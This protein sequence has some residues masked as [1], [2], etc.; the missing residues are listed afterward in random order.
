MTTKELANYGLPAKKFKKHGTSYNDYS[1]GVEQDKFWDWLEKHREKV[2]LDPN[3][4]ERNEILPEP[5][6][7]QEVM[8]NGVAYARRKWSKK[9]EK[10]VWDM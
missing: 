5:V 1:F 8:V 2:S 9:L 10:T 4:F 7:L 6:W 3:K